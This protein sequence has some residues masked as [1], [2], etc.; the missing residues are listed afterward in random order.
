MSE[1]GAV[2]A[3]VTPAEAAPGAPLL[4]VDGLNVRLP[5]DGKSIAQIQV[6][7]LLP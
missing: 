6:T 7:D 2:P 5:I 3:A 1:P 4:D